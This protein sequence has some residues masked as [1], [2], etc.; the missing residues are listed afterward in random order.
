VAWRKCYAVG[1][2][3]GGNAQNE[4][5]Y[6]GIENDERLA[7]DAAVVVVVVAMKCSAAGTRTPTET[8]EASTHTPAQQ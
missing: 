7:D 6:S 3:C 8:V 4:S 2:L 5:C 1:V